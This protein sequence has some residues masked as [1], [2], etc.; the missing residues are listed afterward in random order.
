MVETRQPKP[1]TVFEVFDSEGRPI[2]Q[3]EHPETEPVVGVGAK[4][5]L[6]IRREDRFLVAPQYSLLSV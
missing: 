4:T 5:V 2:G 3:V 6:L 1:L